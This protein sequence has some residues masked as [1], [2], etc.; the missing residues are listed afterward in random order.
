MP[1]MCSS[2][3]EDPLEFAFL[4]ALKESEMKELVEVHKKGSGIIYRKQEQQIS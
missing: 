4:S 2:T 3:A 1:L